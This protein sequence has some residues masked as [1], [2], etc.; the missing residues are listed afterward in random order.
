LKLQLITT[1]PRLELV[2]SDNMKPTLLVNIKLYYTNKYHLK[3]RFELSSLNTPGVT[4]DWGNS[5][6]LPIIDDAETSNE[7]LDV[8]V[9]MVQLPAT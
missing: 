5:I 4:C 7:R 1:R 2:F 9:A 8:N 6:S 3:V